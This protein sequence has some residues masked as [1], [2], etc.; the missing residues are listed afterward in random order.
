MLKLV[1]LI[2]IGILALS[3]FGIS[4]RHIIELPATQENFKFV[5]VL[6]STGW[7]Q[8]Y[9]FVQQFFAQLVAYITQ[10]FSFHF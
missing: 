3:F 6:L 2:V 7:N 5:S 9:A 10:L 1:V 4:L 8:F